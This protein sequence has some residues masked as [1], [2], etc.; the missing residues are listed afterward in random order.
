MAKSKEEYKNF[1]VTQKEALI[2]EYK[3]NLFEYLVAH[4]SAR[5]LGIEERFLSDFGGTAKKR[6]S[7][8]ES[9][10]RQND[11][12]LIQAL[13]QLAR[14]VADF[15]VKKFKDE[16]LKALL[17]VGKSA[18][19]L[20]AQEKSLKEA[21][22]LALIQ[23]EEVS[24]QRGISLKLCKSNAFVNTKSGGLKSFFQTYF[25]NCP[26]SK[27]AQEEL[28]L[29]VDR[30]FWQMGQELYE[31]EGLGD[32]SGH[33]DERWRDANLPELP[34]EMAEDKREIIQGNYQKL[35]KLLHAGFLN[36]QHSDLPAFNHSLEAL[37][38]FGDKDL[39]QLSCF[40][41]SNSK[42]RYRFDHLQEHS[43]IR[44]VLKACP[45]VI[46]PLK[47]GLSSFEVSVGKWAL[48]IRV[49][50]MNKFTQASYKVNCSVKKM[51]K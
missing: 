9:W 31:M 33:F 44:E 30:C 49:K 22:L 20:S 8:Y 16:P 36:F 38:G 12:D 34:G 11:R 35:V 4:L 40:Y 1:G 42:G 2:N 21:D 15:I 24:A 14:P 25:S 3:G 46:K 17:V 13:P 43:D 10:I 23:S 37:M 5:D 7:E 19:G 27:E 28:L 26:G 45:P 18:A 41:Q 51:R 39:I 47:S 50:P 6:L 48:Q 32:F 29:E